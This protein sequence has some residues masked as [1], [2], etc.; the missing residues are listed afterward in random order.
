LQLSFGTLVV[1]AGIFM[2]LLSLPGRLRSYVNSIYYRR[3]KHQVETQ[4]LA[5]TEALV[6][7]I[8]GNQAAVNKK[9]PRK[10]N[11]S[12]E[13]LA[14]LA[15]IH[16]NQHKPSW[17]LLNNASKYQPLRIYNIFRLFKLSIKRQDVPACQALIA[18]LQQAKSDSWLLDFCKLELELLQNNFIK[19]IDIASKLN[20]PKERQAQI[21]CLAAKDPRLNAKQREHYLENARLL[22]PQQ[23]EQH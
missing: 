22:N 15:K 9:L 13:S 3:L 2:W 10:I 19:A 16:A 20:L 21:W 4:S 11:T 23:A 12:L 6:Y 7:A 18:D 8:I 5:I 1:L 17:Q 14:F